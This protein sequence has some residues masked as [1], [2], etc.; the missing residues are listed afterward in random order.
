MNVKTGFLILIIV[1]CLFT[2]GAGVE[3]ENEYAYYADDLEQAQDIADELGAQLISYSYGIASVS[4]DEDSDNDGL[5][6]EYGLDEVS[7]KLYPEL[8]YTLDDEEIDGGQMEQW[9]LDVVNAPKAWRKTKGEGVKVAVIDTGIDDS[10]EDLQGAVVF[11]GTAI[12][13]SYYGERSYYKE[14][15]EGTKDNFGH[16]THVAGIIAAR[17]NGY[18]CTGIAPECSIISI[19][20]LEKRGNVGSGKSSWVATAILQAIDEGADIINMSI[21]GNNIKDELMYEAI[22]KAN[23]NNIVVVCASG[24]AAGSRVYYPAGYDETISVSA[25]EQSGDSVTFAASYSNFGNWIDMCAPGSNIMSTIPGGYAEK[26]GTSMAC[27]IVSGAVALLLSLDNTLAPSQ[28]A[29]ILEISAIDLGSTGKDGKYGYG[30]VDINA[31]ISWLLGEDIEEEPSERETTPETEIETETQNETEIQR[32]VETPRKIET[33]NEESSN[34]E[35][36]EEN[37]DEE[38]MLY[39]LNIAGELTSDIISSIDDNSLDDNSYTEVITGVEVLNLET[40]Y[41]KE[42][43]TEVIS[44][45]EASTEEASTEEV[46]TED[47]STEAII[48]IE[49]EED[50][51]E[52]NQ[53]LKVVLIILI[54]L[55]IAIVVFAIILK[56]KEH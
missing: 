18:G 33:S 55:L 20:A 24:N 11:R 50:T 9:Y 17:D 46:S 10:H 52:K 37:I 26:S 21:G 23:N 1:L 56:R 47:I 44:T 45:E 22:K 14:E 7:V 4:I 16:G 53:I 34:E 3:G 49:E 30:M 31:A 48:T 5:I 54:L 38:D 35:N 27:P 28:V 25:V 32:D 12:P 43:S 39:A 36:I 13:A 41:Y 6:Q 40:D 29:D 51:Q 42:A 2:L 8:V 15:Y 19:K